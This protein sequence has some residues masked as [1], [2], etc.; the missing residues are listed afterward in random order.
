MEPQD[1]ERALL[2]GTAELARRHL[3]Q[4]RNYVLRGRFLEPLSDDQL[5]TVWINAI[6]C[7]ARGDEAQSGIVKDATAEF[8]LRG[9][10][11]PLESVRDLI[12]LLVARG[13]EALSRTPKRER[14]M[15]AARIAEIHRLERLRPN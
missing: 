1:D 14:R 3:E 10:E 13:M 11:P 15:T 9:Q 4:T 8:V 7:W 12:G 6:R 5:S 2:L